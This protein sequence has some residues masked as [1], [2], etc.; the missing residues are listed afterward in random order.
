MRDYDPKRARNRGASTSVRVVTRRKGNGVE[1]FCSKHVQVSGLR[2]L[3][4]VRRGNRVF[5]GETSRASKKAWMGKAKLTSSE[6]S[7]FRNWHV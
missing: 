1:K 5:S 7:F 4:R 3:E 2:P 6:A